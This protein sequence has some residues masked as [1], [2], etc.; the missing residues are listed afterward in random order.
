MEVQIMRKM[1]EEEEYGN[2]NYSNYYVQSPSSVSHAHTRSIS[3]SESDNNNNINII[4]PTKPLL[5]SQHQ[6][7]NLSRCSS[8]RASTTT[9][10]I[11]IPN[12]NHKIIQGALIPVSDDLSSSKTNLK[13]VV[14]LRNNT[15]YNNAYEEDEDYDYDYDCWRYLSFS[16][17]PSSLWIAL[18]L[19]WRFLLSLIFALLVFYLITMP[20]PPHLSLKVTGVR[21]F[22]V[23]EGLDLTGVATN[24]LSCNVSMAIIIDN[25]SKVF[26]L[27]VLSPV[28]DIYFGRVSLVQSQ[29]PE[30]EVKSGEWREME[31][32]AG[33][34]KKAMYG[35]GR[36]MEE[37]LNSGRG[38][39][40]LITLRLSSYIRVIP[41]LIQSDFHQHAHC[42]LYVQNLYDKKHRTQAYNTTCI[43]N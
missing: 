33:T 34:K 19:L 41:N 29:G 32:N 21:Q 15:K 2:N 8:S 39:P 37:M 17:Y 5:H 9:T 22:E 28:V 24:L 10:C 42:V 16:T 38:V 23:A 30:I 43:L 4:P 20:P 35:A 14:V 1:E 26:G 12:H 18:Q 13:N 3:H 40:L 31:V 11:P 7:T 27:N 6:H 36:N 25:K